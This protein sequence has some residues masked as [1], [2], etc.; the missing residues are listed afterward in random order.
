[1]DLNLKGKIAAVMGSSKGL[2]FEAARFLLMDDATVIINSR[3][4]VNLALARKKLETENGKNIYSIVGDVTKPEFA[5]YFAE[6]IGRQFL[7]LDI[8]ITNAGGPP[9]AP[10]ESITDDI[11]YEAI[12]SSFLSHVRMIRACLPLLRKSETASVL[13]ITSYSV[14]QPI[15]NLVLSNAIRSATIGLTKTLALELGKDG[16]RFNSILPGWTKTERVNDLMNSRAE[17]NATS[18]EEELAKQA[19]ESP[20]GRLA[21]PEEFAKVAVFLASPAASYLTGTML[22]VD[23][24]MVK[25]VF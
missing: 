8:L 24:G 10:F 6:E 18:T 20:L 21:E 4:E 1:M 3:N 12:E 23:G 2:G 14:K 15:P 22:S 17:K 19:A 9:P 11:W 16:I 5:N 7:H 13:T 25:G